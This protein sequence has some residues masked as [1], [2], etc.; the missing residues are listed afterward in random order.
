MKKILKLPCDTFITEKNNECMIYQFMKVLINVKYQYF[1]VVNVITIPS[2]DSND[3]KSLYL[4]LDV[5]NNQSEIETGVRLRQICSF[6]L[7]H[8]TVHLGV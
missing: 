1:T 4:S 3:L 6:N 7:R 2:M 5:I 8:S